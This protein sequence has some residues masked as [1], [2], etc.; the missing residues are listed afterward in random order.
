MRAASLADLM[1]MAELESFEGKQGALNQGLDS[2]RCCLV[3]SPSVQSTSSSPVGYDFRALG[4]WR[5]RHGRKVDQERR[6]P[7]RVARNRPVK[8]R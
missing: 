6:A 8:D 7:E 4:V 3:D 2:L 1:V 5:L